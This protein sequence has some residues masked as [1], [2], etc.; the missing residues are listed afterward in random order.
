MIIYLIKDGDLITIESRNAA[1]NLIA[2]GYVEYSENSPEVLAL[3]NKE[4]SIRRVFELK[5]FLSDSDYKIIKC[6]ESELAQEE[7]PYNLQELLAQRKAWR[8]EINQLEFAML[9]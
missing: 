1:D 9:P 6:Y 5:K 3:Q 7:M 8:D 2:E 4:Y